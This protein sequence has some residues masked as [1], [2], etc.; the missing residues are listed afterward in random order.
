M[1]KREVIVFDIDKTLIHRDLHEL[2]LALWSEDRSHRRVLVQFAAGL[3]KLCV[4]PFIRRRFEYFA[5]AFISEEEMNEFTLRILSESELV[6]SGLRRRIERYKRCQYSVVLVSATPER[7]ARPLARQLGVGVHASK[8]ICGILTKDLLAK[9]HRVY[10]LLE[11]D[12]LAV[13]TVYSDSRL[14]FWKHS[15]NY[16]VENKAVTKVSA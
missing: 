7:V 14:D 8:S 2:L 1:G 10:S 4:V 12:A 5:T 9:K 16:L 6:H 11:K 13:K 3:R 15:N